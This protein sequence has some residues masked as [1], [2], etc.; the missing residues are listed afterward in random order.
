[1]NRHE[2]LASLVL[3]AC[4]PLGAAASPVLTI[5]CHDLKGSTLHYGVPFSERL[6]A[7]INGENLPDPHIVGPQADGYDNALTI[8][9]DSTARRKMTIV[10][11]ESEATQKVRANAKKIGMDMI[12]PSVQEAEIV[13]VNRD[14][15]AAL[16]NDDPQG[17]ALY[18]F[19]PK[20]GTM[21]LTTHGELPD[22]TDTVMT[23]V[24]GACEFGSDPFTAL[25]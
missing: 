7:K 14:M 5:T 15:F 18:T 1:M 16:V 19:F 24:R 22:G 23:S 3:F 20:L 9:V 25:R 17:V 2:I 6:H 11:N 4:L 8:V 13:S 10:W 21:F 12:P